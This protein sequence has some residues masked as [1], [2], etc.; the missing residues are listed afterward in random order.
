VTAG[1][2]LARHGSRRDLRLRE[3][4]FRAALLV[5]VAVGIVALITLVAQVLVKGW[6]ELGWGIVSNFPSSLPAKAGASRPSGGR[7][8]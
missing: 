5:S 6:P 7:S 3:S 8:G 2:I 1:S 4:L